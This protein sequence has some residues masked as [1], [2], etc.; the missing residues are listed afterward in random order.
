MKWWYKM[1]FLYDGGFFFSASSFRHFY[2][3]SCL[4]PSLKIGDSTERMKSGDRLRQYFNE[5]SFLYSSSNRP[6]LVHVSG[7]FQ[8]YY[9][10]S[11]S[12]NTSL[13]LSVPLET[14]LRHRQSVFGITKHK[15]LTLRN[16]STGKSVKMSLCGTVGTRHDKIHP[17][18]LGMARGT[19]PSLLW[20]EVYRV[21]VIVHMRSGLSFYAALGKG[22]FK[23]RIRKTQGM[24]EMRGL[25]KRHKTLNI[26]S[27]AQ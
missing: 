1:S 12:T 24:E 15:S 17:N 5:T 7:H 10:P 13:L 27:R 9:F 21:V 20:C 22:S 16:I 3:H 8:L 4:K 18:G 2:C 23:K 25:T 14:A 11:A 26:T 19:L 6:L